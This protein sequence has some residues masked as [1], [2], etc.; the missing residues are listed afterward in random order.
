MEKQTPS[1]G[2]SPLARQDGQVGKQLPECTVSDGLWEECKVEGRKTPRVYRIGRPLGGEQ[3][4]GQQD[5]QVLSSVNRD[6]RR[7]D[8]EWK[9]HQGGEEYIDI[10]I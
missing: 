9:A 1:K 6:G 4:K 7:L 5:R 2:K 8:G 10:E 3:A